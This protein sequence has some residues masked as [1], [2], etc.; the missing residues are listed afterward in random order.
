MGIASTIAPDLLKGFGG[1]KPMAGFPETE[2]ETE[3]ENNMNTT[4][5]IQK[6]RIIDAVNKLMA[7]DSNLA[8]NLERLAKMAESNPQ[9]YKQAVN[10]LK[11]MS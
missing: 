6:K 1:G 11:T 10:I 8:E 7:L 9:V 4:P 3:I 2:T 5:E